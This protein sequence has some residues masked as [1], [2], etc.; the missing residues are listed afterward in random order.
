MLDLR[1]ALGS[2]IAKGRDHH[3]TDGGGANVNDIGRKV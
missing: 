2:I 1:L 3:F